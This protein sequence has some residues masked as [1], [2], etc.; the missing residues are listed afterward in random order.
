MRGAW[1]PAEPV[2]VRSAS[3]LGFDQ[4]GGAHGP[5]SGT[6]ADVDHHRGRATTVSRAGRCAPRPTGGETSPSTAEGGRARCGAAATVG[7][8]SRSGSDGIDP[9][10]QVIGRRLHLLKSPDSESTGYAPVPAAGLVAPPVTPRR[11]PRYRTDGSI[12]QVDG[13]DVGVRPGDG[14]AAMVSGRAPS[15]TASRMARC[16]P[17]I[18]SGSR[19]PSPIATG[20]P[21]PSHRSHAAMQA[22]ASRRYRFPACSAPARRASWARVRS[23]R[24]AASSSQS[25]PIADP[26]APLADRQHRVEPPLP[27]VVAHATAP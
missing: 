5:E 4:V 8:G 21:S 2:S 13:S 9:P 6:V 23:A 16:R 12:G 10:G 24:Y 3:R 22:A 20:R 11:H 18:G 27:R 25:G 14:S 1:I 17:P 15:P 26:D 7:S 19:T